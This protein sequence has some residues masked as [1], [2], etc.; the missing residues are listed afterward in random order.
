M[1]RGPR[2]RYRLIAT[3]AVLAGLILFAGCGGDEESTE[4]DPPKVDASKSLIEIDSGLIVLERYG[5]PSAGSDFKPYAVSL[6]DDAPAALVKEF[7]ADPCATVLG[8]SI[9][10]VDCVVKNSAAQ[11]SKLPGEPGE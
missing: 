3:I 6:D 1:I 10:E 7:N 5:S 11:L 9:G 2:D 8:S 4:Q